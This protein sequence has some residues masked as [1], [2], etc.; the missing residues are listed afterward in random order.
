VF[1]GALGSGVGGVRGTAVVLE[2]A[3]EL[4][5]APALRHGAARWHGPT[6]RVIWLVREFWKVGE[7]RWGR[8]DLWDL[9]MGSVGLGTRHAPLPLP[10]RARRPGSTVD[11][12]RPVD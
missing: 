5:E 6:R 2:G 12:S 9:A 7:G 10:A 3:Q 4:D 8:R 1:G 11:V